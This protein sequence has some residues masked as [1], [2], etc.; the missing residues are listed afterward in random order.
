M[1]S[2]ATAEAMPPAP[3]AEHARD[4]GEAILY[5]LFI[6][7]K[8]HARIAHAYRAGML[9]WVWCNTLAAGALNGGGMGR[10]G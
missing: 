7:S 3:A 10:D 4:Y 2:Y 9:E 6:P 8:S 1:T 5:I